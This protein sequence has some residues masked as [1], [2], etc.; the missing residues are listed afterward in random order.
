MKDIIE[1]YLK[2]V[3]HYCPGITQ[4]EIEYLSEGLTVTTLRSRQF[5]PACIRGQKQLGFVV[6]G[7]LKSCYL[8]ENGKEVTM[9]YIKENDFFTCYGTHLPVQ[10]N[11]RFKSIEPAILVNLSYNHIQSAEGKYTGI[12]L[13]DRLIVEHFI[14]FQRKRIES[15]LF[16]NAEQR[17]LNFM[18]NNRALANR[19]SLSCL[20]T[21]IGVESPSLC[22]IRKKL[23]PSAVF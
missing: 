7:L 10:P 19:V 4:E 14:D 16:E 1:T 5:Y 15:F 13:F 20:S 2:F 11:Y 9:Q 18:K 21:Y 8:G 3:Q 23:I 17:Y 12:A 22:R 6:S